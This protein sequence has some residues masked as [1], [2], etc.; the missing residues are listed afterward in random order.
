MP[1]RMVRTP[2]SQSYSVV[3]STS[4]VHHAHQSCTMV[5]HMYDIVTVME[6][7]TTP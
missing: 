6:I 1:V 3:Q 4:Q 5:N 2:D 7:R